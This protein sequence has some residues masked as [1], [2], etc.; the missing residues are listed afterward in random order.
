MPEHVSILQLLGPIVLALAAVLWV[1]GLARILRRTRP[2]ALP[3]RQDQAL[4]GLPPQRQTAPDREAVELSPA[5]RDAFAGLVRQ[6]GN[7]R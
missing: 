4:S 7:G 3:R 6:L 2:G 5:E 1:T